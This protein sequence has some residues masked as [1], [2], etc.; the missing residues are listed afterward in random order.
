MRIRAKWN[1][2]AL[3]A[4]V[5]AACVVFA[6]AGPVHADSA[7]PVPGSA[8]PVTV[9]ADALP[10]GPDQR[11]RVGQ[12][13]VGN[14]VYVVGSF[15]QGPAG[16]RRRSVTPARSPATTS[17]PTT[18]PPA[19]SRRSTRASMRRH[20]RSPHRPTAPG[21]TWSASSRRQAAQTRNRVAAFNTADGSLI[22]GFAPS[23]SGPVYA[24]AAT[25]STVYLGGSFSAV[26]ATPRTRLAAVQASDGA[27]DRSV[28]PGARRRPRGSDIVL[29]LAVTGPSQVVVGGRFGT[30]NGD[31][32]HGIAAVDATSGATRPFVVGDP[33]KYLRNNGTTSAVTSVTTDGVNV[34][35]SAYNFG[36]AGYLEGTLIAEADGGELVLVNDCRGD[37]Y[38]AYQMNGVM[39]VASHTHNCEMI[40]GSI[41]QVPRVEKRATA[42]T[43]TPTTRVRPHAET[44][45][46][47]K[48]AGT[49]LA[50]NPGLEPGS[51]TGQTQAAWSITGQ[52]LVPVVRR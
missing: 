39:Y 23:V 37:S 25:S 42:F 21:S 22:A 50:W 43:I 19:R 41:E 20:T 3:T 51:Y 16:R 27:R 47:G 48:P 52:R 38:A 32:Q 44:N 45:W 36:G 33:T 14:T 34:Y 4:I 7:P 9:S 31:T 2:T 30:M 11:R 12:V 46:D 18:S 49:Q 5:A 40:G 10:D 15:T 17:S 29:A 13:A 6:P 28:G 35:V 26:G 1:L 8:N 24:V